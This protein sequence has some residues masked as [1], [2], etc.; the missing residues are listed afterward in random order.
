MVNEATMV[1]KQLGSGDSAAAQRLLPLVYEELRA[2]AGSHF[3]HQRADHTLQPTAL[4]HEAFVK[5]IDQTH[6]EYNSRAHFFAVAATAMRQI[7]TDHARRKKADKRGGEWQR[8]SLDDVN[9]QETGRGE[10]DVVA[11]DEALTKLE[12]L[13]PRRHRVVELRFFGG[14]SVDEAAQVLGISRSTVESDWRSARAWLSVELEH[15]TQ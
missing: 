3:R 6:T 10:F 1:L 12:Q 7:L 13:D 2:L 4:V 8:V 11:L 9:R 5:L 15:A 14:L